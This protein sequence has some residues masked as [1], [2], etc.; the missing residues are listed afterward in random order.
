MRLIISV[1]LVLLLLL[2]TFSHI[3]AQSPVYDEPEYGNLFLCAQHALA[4]EMRYQSAEALLLGARVLVTKGACYRDTHWLTSWRLA[5]QIILERPSD[6]ALYYSCQGYFLFETIEPSVREP[7][8]VAVHTALTESPPVLMYHFDRADAPLARFWLS[9]IA[10]PHG[11]TYV[12]DMR[13]C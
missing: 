9:P 13:F 4:A 10:C 7:I 5:Q 12:A 11:I 8:A 2:L 1:I 3:H 6:C